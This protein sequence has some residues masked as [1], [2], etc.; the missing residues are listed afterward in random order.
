MFPDIPGAL[1][2]AKLFILVR[3]PKDQVGFQI[4]T[5]AVEVCPPYMQHHNRGKSLI[6][7]G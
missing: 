5:A 3:P 1:L 7:K 2:G 4:H 6:R